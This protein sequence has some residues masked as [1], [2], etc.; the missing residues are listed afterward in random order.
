MKYFNILIIVFSVFFGCKQQ[1]KT[2]EEQTATIETEN[3]EAFGA[4]MDG[5]DAYD[6]N[7]MLTKYQEMAVTDTT[8]TRFTAKVTEVC[9]SKGCWMKLQLG[10]EK[11]VMVKFK[12]YGFFMPKDIV[13]K[14]V[15]VNGLA[16]VEEMGVEDQRHFAED[17]GKTE[18][19]IAAIVDPKKTFSFEADGVLLKK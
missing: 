6:A 5:D 19:E 15:V 2:A 9:K 12:D 4:L 1:E 8:A 11:E 3:F 18:E 10:Q 17:G 7:E 14:E 16:F 13:G